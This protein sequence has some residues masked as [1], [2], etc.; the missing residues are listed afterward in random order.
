MSTDPQPQS[1]SPKPKKPFLRPSRIILWIIILAALVVA[2]LE[3]RAQ[4]AWSGTYKA[5]DEAFADSEQ[6][7]RFLRMVELEELVQGSPKRELTPSGEILTWR[8][9]L[10]SYQVWLTYGPGGSVQ[11]ISQTEP[12]AEGGD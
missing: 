6:R 4:S 11:K 7:G 8:G 9:V 3:Y 5:F 10:K 2:F 1:P 12:G